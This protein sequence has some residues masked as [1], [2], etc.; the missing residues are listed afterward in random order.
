MCHGIESPVAYKYM[1]IIFMKMV[2]VNV[3][4]ILDFNAS[5]KGS[6]A[7]RAL[8]GYT[9]FLSQHMQNVVSA[10]QLEHPFMMYNHRVCA[11]P[12]LLFDIWNV[13]LDDERHA[14]V[15]YMLA[16]S[17]EL[18][19]HDEVASVRAT[20]IERVNE[21]VVVRRPWH[22]PS[23]KIHS[24]PYV[25]PCYDHGPYYAEGE[26][27]RLPE[28]VPERDVGLLSRLHIIIRQGYQSY[29]LNDST[30]QGIEMVEAEMEDAHGGPEQAVSASN[31]VLGETQVESIGGLQ[32]YQNS[33]MADQ[34]SSEILASYMNLTDRFMLLGEFSWDTSQA[35]D[36]QLIL[37]DLPRHLLSST[38]EPRKVPS[39]LP[40]LMHRYM[41]ADMEIKIQVNSNKFQTGQLQVSW[42]YME[43]F[44]ANPLLGIHSRSQL[45]HCLISAGASNEATLYVPYRCVRPLMHT[46]Q[47][48][49][50]AP[51]LNLGTCAVKVVVPLRTSAAGAQKAGVA[52][53]VR[54]LNAEFTGL[55]DGDIDK[56]KFDAPEKFVVVD[57]EMEAVTMMLANSVID[58]VIGDK[59]C[60]NPSDIRPPEYVVPL[61]GHSWSIG[62]GQS[63][64]INML[65]LQA[66]IACG[67]P[68]DVESNEL[69]IRVPCSVFGMLTHI[70]WSAIS[71]DYNKYGTRLW[72]TSV[73]PMCDKDAVYQYQSTVASDK[74]HLVNYSVP[75]V[76]VVSS[77]FHFWRGSLEYRFDVVASQF[78]TGR[79]L[80]AYIPGLESCKSHI[81]IEQARSSAHIVFSLQEA[82]SFTFTVPYI[83]DRPWWERRYAGPRKRA[84]ASAPSCIYMFV[85]NPLVYTENITPEVTIVPYVRAGLD[86]EVA[87]LVQ[88]A[89]GLSD[90][91]FNYIEDKELLRPKEG[92]SPFYAGE[93][94]WSWGN[95]ILYRYGPV[96]T[97][98]TQFYDPVEADSKAVYI[99]E[100]DDQGG[101][102]K[103]AKTMIVPADGSAS[104]LED[105]TY[106]VPLNFEGQVYAMAFS[107]SQKELAIKAATDWHTYKSPKRMVKYNGNNQ[108]EVENTWSDKDAR[109][110]PVKVSV[111][112]KD[113][114]IIVDAE[115]EERRALTNA[116]Q[117]TSF[118]KSTSSGKEHFG[119][120]FVSLKD[121]LRRYQLY[122]EGYFVYKETHADSRAILQF[123]A[124]PG[125]L[126]LAVDSGVA[127]WNILRDG[128]HALIASGY[129]FF[130]GGMRF[131]IVFPPGL[132][133]NVWVQHHPDRISPGSRVVKTGSQITGV[134][135]Y[136]NHQYGFV[137]QS[138]SVNNVVEF[139]V[140]FYQPGVYGLLRP[141]GSTVTK[142]LYTYSTLGDIIVGIDGLKGIT[143]GMSIAI[144]SS[145]E[146]DMSYNV[147]Q[148]FPPVVYCDE[149][150]E[151]PDEDIK[152]NRLRNIVEAEMFSSTIIPNMASFFKN[153]FV[154]GVGT[155]AA[156]SVGVRYATASTAKD[157]VS[158]S[159]KVSEQ[160][161]QVCDE[162]VDKF[163][164][165]ADR[166]V[167]N[168]S[169]RAAVMV[170]HTGDV[171]VEKV[172]IMADE[173][174][175]KIDNTIGAAANKVAEIRAVAGESA[176]SGWYDSVGMST[177][178]S[179]V[180]HAAVNPAPRTVALSIA[181]CLVA[182]AATKI[183]YVSQLCET[184]TTFFSTYWTVFLGGVDGATVEPESDS[185]RDD[186]T[187]TSL[188][189][190]MVAMMVGFGV[191]RVKP[192]SYGR[193]MRNIS[194]TLTLP[195][196]LIRFL[197]N[198]RETIVYFVKY[199]LW[200]DNDG[201][202][203]QQILDNELPEVQAWFKEASYLLD[204]RLQLKV[205]CERQLNARVYDATALG[206]LL[207]SNGM[208]QSTPT[209]KVIWDMYQKLCLLRHKLVDL[210]QH[211][212]V[213]FECFPLYFFGP[214]GIGKSYLA[215]RLSKDLLN[216]ISYS[217]KGGIMYY[218]PPGQKFWNGY[219]DQPVIV[220]DDAYQVGGTLL[221][222]E[223]AEHFAICS[224]SVFNPNKA[225]VEEK[226]IRGNPLIYLMLSNS[227]FPDLSASVRNQDAVYRRRKKLVEVR[228]NPSIKLPVGYTDAS[229]L[230]ADATENMN[231]L[232]FRVAVTPTNPQTRYTE[233]FSYEGLLAVLKA[234]FVTH[235]TQERENF[236]QRI[237][238]MYCLNPDF[239]EDYAY[240]QIPDLLEVPSLAEQMMLLR[241]RAMEQQAEMEAA[242]GDITYWQHL[243]AGFVSFAGR[244]MPEMEEESFVDEV[245][246][247]DI[248]INDEEAENV[249]DL[250]REYAS[251]M[252]L[253]GEIVEMMVNHP[254]TEAV[255][256]VPYCTLLNGREG[257]TYKFGEREF[258]IRYFIPYSWF[259]SRVRTS[260]Y[261]GNRIV[262][263]DDWTDS[264]LPLH[265]R[266]RAYVLGC[267]LTFV[268]GLG[269]ER[270]REDAGY[271]AHIL[272]LEGQNAEDFFFRAC[273][274][275]AKDNRAVCPCLKFWLEALSNDRIDIKYHSIT[276]KF[277]MIN[278]L[279]LRQEWSEICNHDQSPYSDG[280]MNKLFCLWYET[281][282]STDIANMVRQSPYVAYRDE[283][284]RVSVTLDMFKKMKAKCVGFWEGFV[285][286]TLSKILY[287]LQ[288][289]MPIIIS[290]L[291]L[292]VATAVPAYLTYNLAS[293]LATTSTPEGDNYYKWDAPK[294]MPKNKMPNSDYKFQSANNARSVLAQKITNNTAILRATW[295]Q[296]GHRQ[297][298]E[299]RCFFVFGR[300]LL[301]LRHYIEEFT[302]L[303]SR[304][305]VHDLAFILFCNISKKSSFINLPSEE[306]FDNVLWCKPGGRDFSSNYG[307]L[308]LPS[309]LPSFKNML[310]FIATKN[311]HET[312]G[313]CVDIYPVTGVP[314]YDMPM[315]VRKNYVVASGVNSSSVEMGRVYTYLKHGKGMCGSAVVSININA[316][317]GAII[318]FH[319]A[320]SANSGEGVAEPIYR[321]MF[322]GLFD[323]MNVKESAVCVMNLEP[324]EDATIQ[325]D[326]NLLLYGK[327]SDEFAHPESGKTKIVESPLHAKVF[328]VRTEPNPLRPNDPRQPPGSHPLRDGSN[329]H[330]AGEVKPFPPSLV[331]EVVRHEMED[332]I[333]TVTPVRACIQPL[334]LQQAICGDVDIPYCESLNWKSSEGF[335]LRAYRPST[336]RDK[337][338]VVD[339]EETPEGF[340]LKGLHE[341]LKLQLEL[342]NKC[343]EKNIKCTT[344]YEDCTKDYRLTPEKCKIP[345]KTRIFSVAPIQCTIDCKMYL[346]DFCCAF[347]QHRI[348][349]G[350][351]I[352]IN[353][354]S[355]EWTT[356]V[357]YLHEVGDNIITLD[358]SNYGPTLM[359]QLVE[360]AAEAIVGW[361]KHYG[362]SDTHVRRVE[363]I[364][365][366]DIMN[367]FHLCNDLVYQ[368]LN[369]IASGSP[370]TGEMNSIP[371]KLYMKCCWLLIMQEVCPKLAT[372]SHYDRHI[373]LVVYGD[374]LIMSVSDEAIP[375]FHGISIQQCL[376]RHGIVVTSADKS[377]QMVTHS[378][379]LIATFL[380]RGFAPHPTRK[381][382][383]LAPLDKVSI[384]ECVNWI[385]KCVNPTEA[386]I[387][388]CDAS[389]NMAYGRGRAYYEAHRKLI[390]GALKAL[391]E[392][393]KYKTW[394]ERDR[395][396]YDD[397]GPLCLPTTA[398]LPWYLEVPEQYLAVY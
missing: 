236:K 299:C 105:S 333:A 100:F 306:L 87:V 250:I 79:L 294:A 98:Y 194:S 53:F 81:S 237:C 370:I 120:S 11:V 208:S 151:N 40:F 254:F 285:S 89:L 124:C 361:H 279:G 221:E 51:P 174:T 284:R 175:K 152:Y 198:C 346:G 308:D 193:L 316:G 353:C 99:Y 387:Q 216:A 170:T 331:R 111:D 29:M 348:R 204:P 176:S 382:C 260:G 128:A 23:P 225:K 77:M 185:L 190:T 114:F 83:A 319:V 295:I 30:E 67:R 172:G 192:N 258:R 17:R 144:Y 283:C 264:Q 384:E 164:D 369:G 202:R 335:P 46:R 38:T 130:R 70:R 376:A 272:T 96:I 396:I 118:L 398:I 330:G 289:Y 268:M 18:A 44:T 354:D 57:P 374:D 276:R 93:C 364:L 302:A 362:A 277:T 181:N 329:K 104:Y 363:W 271:S 136:R 72:S 25:R 228:M 166:L 229:C 13:L 122:W 133:C 379:I 273:V 343:F 200:K 239:S 148:G 186:N 218:I 325:L 155:V 305:T 156:A 24:V 263:L 248:S 245:L 345:G 281:K 158:V 173:L 2:F 116:M 241:R 217:A 321:E 91:D 59:N 210:G 213:R 309:Y 262:K 235:Y 37:M 88:P 28:P 220:R 339:L 199:L 180:L 322:D 58:K 240:F 278:T 366:N 292:L 42:Q 397:M 73:H 311:H 247:D 54:F 230:S 139:S 191:E 375:Y 43:A 368:T 270:I 16:D 215:A 291:L 381:G 48:V 301:V 372:L 222:Q 15:R 63:Q 137:I 274:S 365:R 275:A 385:H 214:P 219:V 238:D 286:P 231:H 78:H 196:N 60:D 356:L 84:A 85:L 257:I 182:M 36:Y 161:S 121:V 92:Y 34:S 140:P 318:G 266:I 21:P 290:G 340:K 209:G 288:E 20:I 324:V 127:I 244:F 386:Q 352:G 69:D 296:D 171:M 189:F 95:L 242:E 383:W 338:W 391:G 367:P 125:G 390:S 27:R 149:V 336:A 388:A 234:A 113:S 349:D 154:V 344:L 253:P 378:S 163:H 243:K 212:D 65:R 10:V 304:D 32:L 310:P 4:S 106:A 14:L 52:V 74:A 205:Q 293:N 68:K 188:L 45:P 47:R 75:P 5:W 55:L 26:V 141:L 320:G 3:N 350:S 184:L 380:K 255:K 211:P 187:V 298:Q 7:S 22:R 117:P 327:I 183:S 126:D 351:G 394:A 123:P 246:R 82:T 297:Q 265:E 373:R 224:C 259:P 300:K 178:L 50:Y 323:S 110:R 134:D 107:K 201:V 169:A 280:L 177:L 62:N 267:M 165:V 249:S 282:F 1:N 168:V 101:T 355:M 97:H 312:L 33:R 314:S 207:V 179:N 313:A 252:G 167:A 334:S 138:L 159:G 261:V 371:N 328:P 332:L 251:G 76:G 145:V 326:S 337:R 35:S 142:D 112:R 307:L 61:T 389:I 269:A 80:V 39:F 131:R 6:V 143:K 56:A 317:N 90:V 132:D 129:A 358:Y 226:D 8:P 147:F 360:G 153:P 359:S 49:D 86:F 287:F 19:M 94:S 195:V 115:M 341:K 109:F 233:W 64:P 303:Q 256:F 160:L 162:R 150:V 9:S 146:D 357:N 347:K 342:R 393:R 206:A 71:Q 377:G 31:V 108:K 315:R 227:A 66:S 119:E 392:I 395:E 197:D 203:V 102:S 41:R 157:I 232:Q 12:V 135:A 223:I 103:P